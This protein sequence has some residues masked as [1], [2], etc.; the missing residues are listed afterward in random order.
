MGT[1][2]GGEDRPNSRQPS[3]TATRR[4]KITAR[5]QDMAEMDTIDSQIRAQ[6]SKI[7]WPQ[8]KTTH[9]GER[10]TFRFS[11]I[12]LFLSP[13]TCYATGLSPIAENPLS[14]LWINSDAS[15]WIDMNPLWVW[16]AIL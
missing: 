2:K 8:A 14:S 4:R 1:G 9:E 7:K 13:A 11:F 3:S 10:L 16:R 12:T 5:V 6:Q 15:V